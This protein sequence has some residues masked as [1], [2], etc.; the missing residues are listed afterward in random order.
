MIYYELW[1]TDML[2]A[3]FS[4]SC[5]SINRNKYVLCINLSTVIRLYKILSSTRNY[6]YSFTFK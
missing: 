2:T 5:A 3:I 6:N 1:K 4:D